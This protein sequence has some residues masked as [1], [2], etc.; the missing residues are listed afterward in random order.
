M[1]R[2]KNYNYTDQ[3]LWIK[4][5]LKEILF[6]PNKDIIRRYQCNQMDL[7]FR[8]TT[9]E[10]AISFVESKEIYEIRIPLNQVIGF[11]N[12]QNK[13]IEFELRKDFF[14]TVSIS[15]IYIYIY[16]YFCIFR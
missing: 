5:D 13:Y 2:S 16:L 6:H 3:K 12:F 7:L 8:Y 14:R 1:Y 4:I 10:L 9:Q 15:H 11:K